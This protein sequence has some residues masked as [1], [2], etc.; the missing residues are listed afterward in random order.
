MNR[1]KIIIIVQIMFLAITS[2]AQLNSITAR[3][4]GGWISGNLPSPITWNSGLD[5]DFNIHPVSKLDYRL[6]M[7]FAKD[8][9]SLLPEDRVTQYYPQIIGLSANTYTNQMLS[10]KTFLEGAVG[11]LILKDQTY[12]D[13]NNLSYGAVASVAIRYKLSSLKNMSE[14]FSVG[15]VMDYGIAFTKFNLSYT[16]ISSLIKYSF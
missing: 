16:S 13:R 4:G 3:F 14:F 1:F 10:D 8:I 15:I 2:H 11:V 12:S 6:S 9:K 5:I 7:F